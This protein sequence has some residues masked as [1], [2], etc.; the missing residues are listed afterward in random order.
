MEL[1]A[2]IIPKVG[3]AHDLEQDAGSAPLKLHR[4]IDDIQRAGRQQPIHQESQPFR[5]RVDQRHFHPGGQ[6]EHLE[7]FRLGKV[8]DGNEVTFRHSRPRGPG[9]QS[10]WQEDSSRLSG[11]GARR[12]GTGQWQAWRVCGTH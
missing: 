4:N 12:A 7:D 8:G 11:A 9:R 1:L 3:A 5:I 10:N 2:K 6:V